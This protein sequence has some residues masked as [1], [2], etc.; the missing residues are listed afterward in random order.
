MGL[1][2]RNVSD[3][4]T[5]KIVEAINSRLRYFLM[6]KNEGKSIS[7]ISYLRLPYGPVPKS[8]VLILGSMQSINAIRITEEEI[9]NGYTKIIINAQCIR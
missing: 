7:G 1:K 3:E 8:H 5:I 6:F 9:S 4:G 2:W